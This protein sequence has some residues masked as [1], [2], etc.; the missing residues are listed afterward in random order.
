MCS[1]EHGFRRTKTVFETVGLSSPS[2]AAIYNKNPQ[3]LS[4]LYVFSNRS[5]PKL[6]VYHHLFQVCRLPEETV[7][8]LHVLGLGADEMLQGFAVAVA[9]GNPSF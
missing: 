9:S 8:G 3:R 2:H 6:P 1:K 5:V 4:N 7:V